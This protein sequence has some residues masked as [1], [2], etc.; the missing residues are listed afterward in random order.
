M[1]FERILSG[2]L[3]IRVQK[4]DFLFEKYIKE[5][6]KVVCDARREVKNLFSARFR[7]FYSID[8]F[9]NK[10]SFNFFWLGVYRCNDIG[11]NNLVN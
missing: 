8:K 3:V 2:S 5:F 6:A 4:L 11:E 9:E 7:F 1:A 10:R